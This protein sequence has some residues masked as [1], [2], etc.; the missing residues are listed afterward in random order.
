MV[1][2]RFLV[3][4]NLCLDILLS[5]DKELVLYFLNTSIMTFYVERRDNY[6]GE[7]TS[8]TI[9]AKNYLGKRLYVGASKFVKISDLQIHINHFDCLQTYTECRSSTYQFSQRITCNQ[10]TATCTCLF[11]GC[12]IHTKLLRRLY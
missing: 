6:K 8:V 11:I 10:V 1:S 5:R 12:V 7:M 2:H 3:L 9:L 4:P